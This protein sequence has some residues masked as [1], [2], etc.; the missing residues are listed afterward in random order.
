MDAYELSVHVPYTQGTIR[1]ALTQLRELGL[2][3]GRRPV[4][5][6]SR[7]YNYVVTDEGR[8]LLG[9]EGADCADS[10]TSES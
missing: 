7:R 6:R 1:N 8:R 3:E 2:I 4:E 10:L 9:E 5:R